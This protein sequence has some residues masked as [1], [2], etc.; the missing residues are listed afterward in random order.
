[1]LCLSRRTSSLSEGWPRLEC[2]FLRAL[3]PGFHGLLAQGSYQVHWKAWGG[4][5]V[6][7]LSM[8]QRNLGSRTCRSGRSQTL[9]LQCIQKSKISR[10]TTRLPHMPP[11]GANKVWSVFSGSLSAVGLFRSPVF[12]RI[13]RPESLQRT[14]YAHMSTLWSPYFLTKLRTSGNCQT[15]DPRACSKRNSP[16]RRS[17]AWICTTQNRACLRA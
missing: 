15:Q 4:F 13:G 16:P 2:S 5:C 11:K 14:P 7:D 12:L 3:S 8:L 1:M 6:S 9:T 17:S 10:S